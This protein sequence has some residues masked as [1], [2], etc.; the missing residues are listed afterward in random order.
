VECAAGL[1]LPRGGVEPPPQFFEF[2]GPLF[3]VRVQPASCVTPVDGRRTLRALPRDRAGR[4]ITDAGVGFAWTVVEGGGTIE[5]PGE[6]T[7]H[8]RAPSEPGLARI[9]LVARQGETICRA[10]ALV[11]VTD[12]LLPGGTTRPG[13]DSRGI[14]GYTF[15][16]APGEL[17]RSR[18]DVDR[19][20]I[21]VNSGHRDFV[22][23][24]RQKALK[25]RYL[26]RLFAKELVL[27]NFAGISP[28]Q[29]L[30]RLIELTLY[31]EES[32]K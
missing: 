9:E 16:R 29:L 7:A 23:A 6:Q 11:T 24:A 18:F 30:E 13:G 1:T 2:A 20:L 22:F 31:S 14:P 3:A 12:T 32:L 25:L 8:F 26:T 5:D 17:W 28:D 19:N 21:V 15:E 4:S 10:E 27:R